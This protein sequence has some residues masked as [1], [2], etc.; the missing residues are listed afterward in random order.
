LIKAKEDEDAI[1]EQKQNF[2]NWKER[3]KSKFQESRTVD[4]C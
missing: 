2:N 4:Y 3:K 1:V